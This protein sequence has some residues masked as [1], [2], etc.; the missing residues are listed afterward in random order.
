[1]ELFELVPI[2]SAV[3]NTIQMYNV[4]LSNKFE[5]RPTIK[6]FIQI[7][8]NDYQ[9]YFGTITVNLNGE[10]NNKPLCYIQYGKGMIID[11]VSVI[12]QFLKSTTIGKICAYVNSTDESMN[13]VIYI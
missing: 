6:Q 10:Y 11:D 7:L 12:D 4:I 5:G 9:N 13:F 1:M 2:G 8:I 3:F